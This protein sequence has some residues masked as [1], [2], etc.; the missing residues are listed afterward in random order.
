MK[1]ILLDSPITPIAD[2]LNKLAPLL[3]VS[4]GP[5]KGTIFFGGKIV[6]L[7]SGLLTYIKHEDPFEHIAIQ[8]LQD[9]ANDVYSKAGSGVGLVAVLAVGLVRAA[10]TL[11][12]AGYQPREIYDWLEIIN[13]D[14]QVQLQHE[15]DCTK[16]ATWKGNEETILKAIA[17]TAAKDINI[18]TTVGTMCHKIGEFAHVDILQDDQPELRVEYRNGF[19]FKTNPMSYQFLKGKRKEF[20]N[21]RILIS[22][23][24]L[25]DVHSVL[26][27]MIAVNKEQAPLILI[28]NGISKDVLTLLLHNLNIGSLDVMVLKTPEFTFDQHDSLLDIAKITGGGLVSNVFGTV[29]IPA[30]LGTAPRVVVGQ[31][32]C[33]VY[34]TSPLPEKYI[35]DVENRAKTLKSPMHQLKVK[36][37]VSNLRGQ[38]AVLRVGGYTDKEKRA[39][40]QRVES[41]LHTVRGAQQEG[42][43]AGGY[44][45]FRRFAALHS[46]PNIPTPLYDGMAMPFRA[47]M[48]N[49]KGD[50]GPAARAT[51]DTLSLFDVRYGCISNMMEDGVIDSAKSIRVAVDSAISIA[52]MLATTGAIVTEAE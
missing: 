17:T 16:L 22:D 47:L 25:N 19:T 46:R 38:A 26:E 24:Q 49:Y 50:A 37:R 29:A 23:I 10:R 40:Y 35:K 52:K 20:V 7:Y 28:A 32:Y 41:T 45:I 15:V 42:Y 31:D 4:C 30:N 11:L 18:G 34:F 27:L 33:T 1:R 2:G 39:G 6:S 48:S 44:Q 14:F 21:P 51:D 43:V 12:V 9:V 13:R 3:L 8:L 5:D 36:Q